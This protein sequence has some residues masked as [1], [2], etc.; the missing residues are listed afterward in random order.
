MS[1][2]LSR[3]RCTWNG[4]SGGSEDDSSGCHG[5]R[6]NA[7]P[8]FGRISCSVN[9]MS[10][11]NIGIRSGSGQPS[12]CH[13]PAVVIVT[14]LVKRTQATF[15]QSRCIASDEY[16]CQD[17]GKTPGGVNLLRFWPA[18]ISTMTEQAK[19]IE[20]GRLLLFEPDAARRHYYSKYVVGILWRGLNDRGREQ[21]IMDLLRQ[22]GAS[23]SGEQTTK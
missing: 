17:T 12:C 22:R 16:D 14:S 7:R 19:G 13:S 21:R 6:R 3:E 20:R 11:G 15:R 2:R 1:S 5:P 9:R 4:A 18:R 23:L 10:N 8:S